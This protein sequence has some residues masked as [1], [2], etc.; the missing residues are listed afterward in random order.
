MKITIQDQ[1]ALALAFRE[2]ESVE[3]YK[4]K[5]GYTSDIEALA[6]YNLAESYYKYLVV[7]KDFTKEQLE[8]IVTN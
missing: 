1:A 6:M 8:E 7:F 2:A 4:E 3:D 5:H